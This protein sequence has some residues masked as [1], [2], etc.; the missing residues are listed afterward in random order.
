M[1]N[2]SVWQAAGGTPGDGTSPQTPTL[3]VGECFR[4][5]FTF[6]YGL[7]GI[8][9][10]AGAL[11]LLLVMVMRMGYSDS[12]EYDKERNFLYSNKGT[13]GTSGFMSQKEMTEV[14]DL[15]PTLKHHTGTVLGMIDGKY[16]CVPKDTRLNANIA[17][18]GA[19]GSMKTRAFCTNRILQSAARGESLVI[20]D[21]KSELYEKTSRYLA[22][23]RGYVVKVF[24]LVSP[25]NSDSWNC[26]AEIKGD[27]L[28]AQLFCDVIIKNTGSERGDHFWDAAE[29]NLLKALV[30]YVEQGY[31]PDRKN[32][33]QVY[34]LLTLSSEK[35]LNSL[36]DM[37]PST[38]P[39]K[40][41]FTIFK[42]ASDT[43]RSGVIIG[44]GSRLQVFQNRMICN[45]TSFDEIDL[46]LPC[47]KPCAYFV[48]NSDQDSTFDFLASLF[49]SFVFIR[50]VR[51]A[52]KHCHGGRLEVPVHVL[53]EELTACGVIPDLSRKISTI[54]SRNISMS[55][56]FQN[57]A[58]LQ[59]RYPYNQWQEILGNCDIHLF[60]GCVDELT[61]QHI[62][63]RSGEVSVH[64]QSKAKQLGTWRISNYTPEYR[65]TSGVG[66]RKLLTMD[67]VLRLPLTKAL[68]IVH[69]KKIL[70]VD[71]CDY[72]KHPEAKKLQPCKAS[73][74]IP[75]WSKSNWKEADQPTEKNEIKKPTRKKQNAAPTGVV[76]TTKDDIMSDI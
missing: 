20:C 74:H 19:S 36:F 47:T 71:K 35:E 3:A 39:A 28:M 26:I 45:I 63:D 68:V 12:G 30:L 42:Q 32:I 48:I 51:Y 49:L 55:C 16:V 5:I 69:G 17:V 9:V 43:V 44:L 46:E 73:E 27:E 24:N 38:H 75:E 66:K 31:P 8:A 11:V 37:L 13:Y 34:K 2:Y 4:V 23:E 70:Q 21:P 41:P 15:V 76:A 18:Y 29:M 61:A 7:V 58:G 14:L 64:V 72:T 6:P 60:L 33:G 57:L 53:G 25:E 65:E 59:N 40:A 56:V 67:E 54:R 62:S 1:R 52:D 50:T 10:C 22:E